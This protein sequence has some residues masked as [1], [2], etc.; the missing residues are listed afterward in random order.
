[1]KIECYRRCLVFKDQTKEYKAQKALEESEKRFRQ[2]FENSI[3]AI[4]ILNAVFDE[5]GNLL[6]FIIIDVN[7]SLERHT[8]LYP[9]KVVGH[10]FSEFIPDLLKHP[11]FEHYKNVVLNGISASF[12]TYYEQLVHYYHIILIR[13]KAVRLLSN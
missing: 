11:S 2:L 1:M 13:S 6:D 9:E 8:G 7:S 4:L 12:D 3:S 5:N 10:Y